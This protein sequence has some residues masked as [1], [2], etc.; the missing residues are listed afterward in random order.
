METETIFDR[1]WSEPPINPKKT[2]VRSKEG[3]RNPSFF[4]YSI[5]IDSKIR[6]FWVFLIVVFLGSWN[7]VKWHY[8]SV[9]KINRRYPSCFRRYPSRNRRYRRFYCIPVIS[10]RFSEFLDIIF[11]IFEVTNRRYRRLTAATGDYKVTKSPL[12]AIY[13]RH[14]HFWGQIPQLPL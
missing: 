12:P 1:S 8:T 4:R 3:A 9:L 10:F 5:E 2:P 6:L 7:R 11:H 13:R 14:R